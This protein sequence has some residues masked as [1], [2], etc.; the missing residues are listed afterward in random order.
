[1]TMLL[2]TQTWGLRS[3]KLFCTQTFWGLVLTYKIS[4]RTL[5]FLL[6]RRRRTPAC[7]VPVHICISGRDVQKVIPSVVIFRERR[8]HGG[9]SFVGVVNPQRYKY[10]S[11]RTFTAVHIQLRYVSTFNAV[12]GPFYFRSQAVRRGCPFVVYLGL[13]LAIAFEGLR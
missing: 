1:M 6:T 2:G 12:G 10:S 4:S 3:D 11:S 7:L 13:F 9:E 5:S 8:G